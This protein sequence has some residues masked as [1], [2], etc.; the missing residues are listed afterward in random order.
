MKWRK[1]GGFAMYFGAKMEAIVY[2][3][4][5]GQGRVKRREQAS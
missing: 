5:S 4:G 1:V 2:E 3:L